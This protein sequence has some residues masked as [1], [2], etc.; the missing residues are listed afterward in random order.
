MAIFIHSRILLEWELKIFLNNMNIFNLNQFWDNLGYTQFSFLSFF[1]I[2][3][4]ILFIILNLSLLYLEY[5]DNKEKENFESLK[6]G[7]SGEVKK[8]LGSFLTAATAYS[9]YITI[10][11]EVRDNNK[12]EE[13]K[14]FYLKA[15]EETNKFK[16]IN[17]SNNLSNKL[18][19]YSI[20]KSFNV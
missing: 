13:Y 5:L 7:V 19:Y 16:D 15:K 11:N 8:I 1:K 2:I 10:R 3:L 17:L 20:D 18:H 4:I 9:T 6:C 12:L 14:Q